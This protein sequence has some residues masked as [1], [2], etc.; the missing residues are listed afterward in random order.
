MKRKKIVVLL[1]IGTMLAAA[2]GCGKSE[3]V[4]DPTPTPAPTATPAPTSTPTPAPTPTVTPA[5]KMIGKKTSEAKFI[6]LSNNTDKQFR[7]LYL[8]VSGNEDWGN[9][10]IPSES[11]VHASEKVRMYYTPQTG[12]GVTYDMRLT[13]ENGNTYEIDGADLSDMETASLRLDTDQGIVYLTYVS[14]SSNSEKNTKDSSSSTGTEDTSGMDV[15]SSEQGIYYYDQSNGSS[16]GGGSQSGDNSG[17]G[18]QGTTDNSGNG[19]QGTTDN[20][21]NGGQNTPD[22][23][24]TTGGGSQGGNTGTD[25]SGSTAGDA[26]QGGGDIDYDPGDGSDGSENWTDNIIWDEDGNWQ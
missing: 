19:N 9:S 26:N 15:S 16:N 7:K 5:P 12:E 4:A 17:N 11:S 13:D 3:P 22:S 8:R 20:S 23:S 24:G 6:Y 21:G 1:T 18:S 10:L 2:S 25:N 14:K